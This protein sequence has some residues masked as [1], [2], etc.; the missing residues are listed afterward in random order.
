VQPEVTRPA[1]LALAAAL[2]AASQA[3]AGI[4]LGEARA[5]SSLG[6]PLDA[7]I[8]FTVATGESAH[9]S[10]FALVRDSAD[11]PGTLGEGILT[12]ERRRG[13]AALRVRTVSPVMEPT[14]VIRVRAT[15]P[16]EPSSP[17]RQFTLKL[18]A[19]ASATPAAPD[20]PAVVAQL[21]ARPGDTLEAIAATVNPR[22]GEARRRYLAGLKRLN[23]SLADATIPEGTQVALPDPRTIHVTREE[24]R[25]ASARP[26]REAREPRERKEPAEAPKRAARTPRTQ[27]ASPAPRATEPAPPAQVPAPI[28]TVA[29]TAER[30]EP[31]A[32]KAPA[33]APRTPPA[34][35][36]PF[37]LKLSSTEV[38]LAPS[39][40]SF[41]S[42][43]RSTS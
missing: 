21:R 14:V 18:D 15:C 40:L 29:S 31:V 28:P 23:P 9:A 30:T 32:K 42:R 17:T 8:P 11:G 5:R 25:L 37:V 20:L 39:F 10:C 2:L 7:R 34:P 24:T 36:S 35:G 3:A 13:E 33:K 38:D 26:P 6:E 19:V 41:S 27:S 22:E 4:V 43:T 16:G 1:R 12:I